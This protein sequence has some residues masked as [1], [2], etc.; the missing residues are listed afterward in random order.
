MKNII[1][2]LKYS[3][4]KLSI[5]LKKLPSLEKLRLSTIRIDK[6]KY[7]PGFAIISAKF[8]CLVYSNKGKLYNNLSFKSKLRKKIINIKIP[9]IT[10]MFNTKE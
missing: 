8:K 2:L 9:I 3:N 6:N 5:F 10:Y 7:K 1:F 4:F